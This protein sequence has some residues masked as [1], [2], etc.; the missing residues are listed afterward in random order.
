MIE[1][2]EQ[3]SLTAVQIYENQGLEGLEEYFERQTNRLRINSIGFFDKDQKLIAGDLKVAPINDLFEAAIKSNGPEFKRFTDRTYGAQ[4]VVLDDGKIFIYVI[5]LKRF[6]PPPFF[7]L[8]LTLQVLA[9]VLIGGLFCY[10]LAKYLTSPLAQLRNATHKIAEGNFE[11]RVAENFGKRKDEVADLARDFDEMAQ[12]IEN[13]IESEKRLTQDISHELRS[14]L[15]RMN[16]ALELAKT[17]TTPESEKLIKRIETESGR[18]NDLIGQ[19]LT[20]SKL[21]TGSQSFEKNEVNLTRLI[22]NVTSDAN[23]EARANNKEVVLKK[24]DR[25]KVSGNEMLLRSAIENVLRNAIRY[26][27]EQTEVQVS[28]EKN[29][30]AAEISIR[31]YGEGVPEKDLEKL[32]KPFYRVHEARD[33]KTGGT[34]L[35]LAIAEQAVSNHQGTIK[36]ENTEKGLLVKIKLPILN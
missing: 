22:E 5:E 24:S 36:A 9:V 29:G 26:T 3:N 20:L 7:T 14:P 12:R 31:D 2:I 32:F 18:L 19:L 10:F 17:R 16:V 21:E 25:V 4:K 6:Q 27:E 33:R 13:L 30:V 35:G 23:F 15:A 8:R 1:A 34:G 11:T 28:I